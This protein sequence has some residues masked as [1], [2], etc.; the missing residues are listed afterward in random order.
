MKKLS[1]IIIGAGGRGRTYC[2]NM[3]A[4]A[5]KYDIV[6]V[7]E[8]VEVKRNE[9][10][11]LCG[12]PEENCFTDWREIL[13]RPKMADIAV[14]ATMDAM[15]YEPAMKAISLGYH[16]LLEKPVAPTAKECLDIAKAAEEKG[17][18][19][20]VCH[21]LRY[22]PFYKTLKSIV[23]SGMI[24]KVM[25][26]EQIEGIGDVHF[27]HSFVRGL[28][29][30][31]KETSPMVIAK[32]C[33]DLDIIQWLI[34]SS[35]KKVSSFGE[36][37]Y[38]REENAPVG[39]P[40]RCVDGTCPE[41]DTCPY[42]AYSLYIENKENLCWK[43]IFTYNVA[44]HSDFTD[45]ELLE[46]LKET[47]W[48]L[49]VFHANNDMPDH[50]LVNMEFEGGVHATLNLNAFNSGGRYTR[51]FGTKGELFAFMSDENIHVHTFSDKKDHVISVK[52][53]E[54]SIAGGHGGGDAG[55]VYDLYEY[56]CGIYQGVSVS[57]IGVS[58]S[59][60][61]IGFAAEEARHGDIVVS[62]EQFS[63][64]VSCQNN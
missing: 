32:T 25:S 42:N 9:V 6:G 4:M 5:D 48:G 3:H 57:D 31:E 7:A 60:H 20:I 49:C 44:T 18:A 62:L 54:E 40:R 16:L 35:C 13:A 1:V 26:V 28:W 61:L 37:T 2:R 50:Q 53:T 47:D 55:I 23:D 43:K 24:G 52:K 36:L 63:E 46:K 8:P 12:I 14:I 45:E 10:R 38:F 51:I 59:N 30:S 58:V 41:K 15:H 19:V 22:S 17:V 39:A 34:G 29:H 21:V 64:K 33:H 11:D 27:S 56:L